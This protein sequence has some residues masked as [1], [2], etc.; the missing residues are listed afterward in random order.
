MFQKKGKRGKKEKHWPTLK[1]VSM[2]EETLKK[3][4]RVS[5]AE[6]KRKLPRQV[7]HNTL[8]LILE[9]LEESKKILVTIK[10]LTWIHERRENAKEKE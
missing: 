4:G 6:L 9:Y 2:V 8:M 10:G 3:V 1:T 5:I 7:N